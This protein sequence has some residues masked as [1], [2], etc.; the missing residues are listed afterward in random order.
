MRSSGSETITTEKRRSG[1]PALAPSG[2]WYPSGSPKAS[3]SPAKAGVY[4]FGMVLLEMVSGR[5][6]LCSLP[7]DGMFLFQKDTEFQVQGYI[8]DILDPRA[9]AAYYSNKTNLAIVKRMIKTALRCL[10]SAEARPSMEEVIN[11]FEY[12]TAQSYLPY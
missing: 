3:P 2:T 1:T 5:R 4:S 12:Y 10:H 6:K 8:D 11:Q 7:L 9:M